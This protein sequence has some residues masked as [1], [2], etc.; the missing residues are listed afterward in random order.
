MLHIWRKNKIS[1]SKTRFSYI[2][3]L[4]SLSARK[5]KCTFFLSFRDVPTAFVPLGF[6][7]MLEGQF[8]ISEGRCSVAVDST[9]RPK[10]STATAP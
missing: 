2:F 6:Y 9:D 8:G 1:T 3:S 7:P 5:A 4:R 10:P